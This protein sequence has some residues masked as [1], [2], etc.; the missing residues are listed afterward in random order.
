LKTREI[1]LTDLCMNAT[2]PFAE[3][4]SKN[5][6]TFAGRVLQNFQSAAIQKSNEKQERPL[7]LLIVYAK[8][9]QE[10][11]TPDEKRAVRKFVGVLKG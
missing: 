11:L 6:P 1:F 9:R 4:L 7:Y 5:P 10:N 2:W 8:A 3:Q